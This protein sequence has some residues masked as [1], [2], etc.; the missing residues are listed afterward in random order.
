MSGPSFIFYPVY[1][2][3]QE[4]VSVAVK[5]HQS[6]SEVTKVALTK[7]SIS[8][9]DSLRLQRL[10]PL[11]SCQEALHCTGRR[12][13]GDESLYLDY[14][15]VGREGHWDCF[16]HLK[17]KAHPPTRPHLLIVPLPGDCTFRSM[18]L[19]RPFLFKPPER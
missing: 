14:Q 3:S 5:R 6:N 1:S 15:A 9:G 12:P 8:L 16:E 7:E 2:T 10:S 4:R 19:R 11:S 18:S 13:A 17:L